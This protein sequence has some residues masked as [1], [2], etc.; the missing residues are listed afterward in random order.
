M[1]KR[2]TRG[3][4]ILGLFALTALFVGG[5]GQAGDKD[6]PAAEVKD[7]DKGKGKEDDS[8]TWWCPEHG[9]PEHVCALCDKKLVEKFKKDGDWCEEH[10]RPESQCFLCN[11]KRAEKFAAEYRARYGKEPPPVDPEHIKGGKK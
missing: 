1:Q 2:M 10:A 3:G 7:K 5:C 8:A 11:A 6:K 4:L 9:V